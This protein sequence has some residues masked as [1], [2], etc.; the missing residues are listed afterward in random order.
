MATNISSL[1]RAI[2]NAVLWLNDVQNELQWEDREVVYK[3]TKAVLQTIRDRLPPGEL[4]HFSANL[5]MVFKGMLFDSYDH[6]QNKE[7]KTVED[8]FIQVQCH[9]DS[10]MR[11]IIGAQEATCGVI[12][13]LFKRIGE[14][15]MKKVAD[16]MP[17]K[18]KSLFRQGSNTLSIETMG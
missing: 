10:Q 7:I 4:F 16:A 3:A 9:Y 18:L 8:F 6:E 14:G 17:L 1:D 15:E 13:T 5:P 11:D 2:Q 12:N